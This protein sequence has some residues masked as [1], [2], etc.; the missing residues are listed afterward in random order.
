MNASST[1]H[2]TAANNLIDIAGLLLK[3]GMNID[4]SDK[5]PQCH[6]YKDGMYEWLIVSGNLGTIEQNIMH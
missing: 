4:V 3:K 5:V 2:L 6:S 1:L